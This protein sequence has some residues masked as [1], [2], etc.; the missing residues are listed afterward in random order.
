EP[1]AGT[2]ELTTFSI[3]QRKCPHAVEVLDTRRSPVVVRRQ[4]HL[5]VR[6]G[7][8][9]VSVRL[10]LQSQLHVVVD[11]PVVEEAV[12]IAGVGHRLPA[13]AREVEDRQAAMAERDARLLPPA[14]IV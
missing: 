13:G 6:A 1:V 10:E 4:N 11:L 12:A 2:E 9:A 8:E 7:P 3:P 5:G 14:V